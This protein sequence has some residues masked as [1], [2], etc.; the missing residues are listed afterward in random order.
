MQN[1]ND[2]FYDTL[3]LQSVNNESQ[4]VASDRTK[5][6]YMLG[7]TFNSGMRHEVAQQIANNFNP[8]Q[9]EESF[10]I[11]EGDI[12][13]MDAGDIQKRNFQLLFSHDLIIEGVR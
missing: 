7:S 13:N 2:Q 6:S 5:Q 10:A 12:D 8:E 3:N 11:D 4:E 1:R 9:E